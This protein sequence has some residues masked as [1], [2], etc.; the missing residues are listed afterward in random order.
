MNSDTIFEWCDN[1]GNESEIS[2]FGGYCE[3]CGKFLLP[4]SQCDMNKVKCE[5]CEFEKRGV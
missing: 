4:C 5:N 3:H 2:R 1:C